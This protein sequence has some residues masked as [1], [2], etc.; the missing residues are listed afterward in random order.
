MIAGGPAG[1]SAQIE[2][3]P[4]ELIELVQDY[5]RRLSV[6]PKMLLHLGRNL[7]R[8]RRVYRIAGASII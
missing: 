7:N 4:R 6:T 1:N 3:G 5:T 8:I 2:G